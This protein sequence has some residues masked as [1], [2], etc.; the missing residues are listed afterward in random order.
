MYWQYNPASEI[1]KAVRWMCKDGNAGN[2]LSE[3][4]QNNALGSMICDTLI[5]RIIDKK[6]IN[7]KPKAYQVKLLARINYGV[8]LMA[9]FAHMTSH[10]QDAKHIPKI[11]DLDTLLSMHNRTFASELAQELFNGD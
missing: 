8:Y 7:I 10:E 5:Q 11:R 1:P 6:G 9:S 4:V 2:H 3:Y